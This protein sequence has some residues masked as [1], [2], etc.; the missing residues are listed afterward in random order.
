MSDRIFWNYLEELP[1]QEA[2]WREWQSG[3]TGWHRFNTFY[4][5]YL[6]VEGSRAKLL[7][8]TDLCERDCPR[9][10]VENS[11][12]DIKAVCP[13]NKAEPIQLK[14]RDILI[15]S[16]RLEAFHQTLCASLSIKYSDDRRTEHA[17]VWHLG[18]YSRKE[19]YLTYETSTLTDTISSIY[20]SLQKPFIL[21]VPTMK[22]ITPEIQQF[23]AK[24]NS[25]L[26]S[27]ADELHLQPDGS[28]KPLRGITEFM[29][30]HKQPC[31]QRYQSKI[32]PI[33]AY[34]FLFYSKS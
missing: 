14:F 1:D 11:P 18:D 5:Y 23:M 30:L 12:S 17:N 6:R 16:L 28:F 3:L 21:M 8:C 27:M 9:R 7:I 32:L 4:I 26:L 13:Q 2:A 15:Y 19:V 34:K 33:E 29:K 25:V 20:I 10:V 31:P 22:N 24:N